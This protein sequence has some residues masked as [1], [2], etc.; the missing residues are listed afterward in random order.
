MNTNL[1]M[2][3]PQYKSDLSVPL[4]VP[5]NLS[6]NE[7]RGW[8]IEHKNRIE[9]KKRQLTEQMSR[10]H[11][12]TMP[13]DRD[14]NYYAWIK[15]VKSYKSLL[16]EEQLRLTQIL[17]RLNKQIRANR[18]IKNSGQKPNI[19]LSQCFMMAAEDLLEPDAFR[20]IEAR[21]HENS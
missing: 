5:T 13:R 12:E 20:E 19:Q 4:Q 17:G 11:D 6:D 2:Q 8:L 18:R 3:N 21:G 10:Y 7:L 1:P 16:T 9:S 14:R 15:R